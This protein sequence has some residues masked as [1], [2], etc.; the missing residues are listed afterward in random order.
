MKFRR[1]VAALLLA[2]TPI[3]VLADPPASFEARFDAA[4][5]VAD[6]NWLVD[7][8]GAHYAYLPDDHIDLARLRALYR[9]RAE[10]ATTRGA[11]I[12]L[13]EQVIA[14]LHD[15]HATLGVNTPS[16]PNLVPTGAD[17]W[18]RMRAGSA[19]LTEVRPFSPASAAGLRAGDV[20]LSIAGIPVA[21]AVASAMPR[22]LT[23][24]DPRAADVT[25][26]S[27]LAGTH[28]APRRIALRDTRGRVRTVTLAP[29]DTPDSA[30]PV[31]WRRLDAVTGYIRIENS[32]GDT[33][34]VA[35][36]D[37]ALEDL[38]GAKA[39]ILDLRDT[40][41]GGDSDV[42]EPII[43]RF[44]ARPAAYQ[45]V[46]DPAPGK[47]FPKDSWL[48]TV[49]PRGPFTARARLVV[50][51]DHWTGSMGEGMAVGFDAL[52][53]ATIVGAP[54]AGLRGGTSEFVLPRTAIPVHLPT[55]RL[56][57]VDGRPR[58]DFVPPVSVDLARMAGSD[59]ILARGRAVLRA[60]PAAR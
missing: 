30:A 3:A 38:R 19:V 32:L 44:I 56:Y 43:G 24:P 39:L 58:E 59:P 57:H 16:S 15:P 28:D 37:N 52:H 26:R 11:W 1:V 53:R 29:Y 50:L 6:L 4:A 21:K 8:I 41:S 35:A 45:R 14:E 7:Q 22:A 10:A 12:H 49:Q 42:A 20:V 2:L 34:T 40:P 25:L 18:A 27:L 54:M 23:R 48:K 5:R 46:F 33:A 47:R 31:T 55:E 51:V 36:F 17:L 60:A 13:I 9:P